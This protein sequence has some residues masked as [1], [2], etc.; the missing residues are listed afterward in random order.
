MTGKMYCLMVPPVES[1][2]VDG[3]P[4]PTGEERTQHLQDDWERDA[5]REGST[6]D[7]AEEELS[8]QEFLQGWF[9]LADNWVEVLDLRRYVDFVTMCYEGI[10]TW[11]L[12]EEGVRIWKD[13]K[14]IFY[15]AAFFGDEEVDRDFFHG[16]EEGEGSL[17]DIPDL[18]AGNFN[19]RAVTPFSSQRCRDVILDIYESRISQMM[20]HRNRILGMSLSM[21]KSKVHHELGTFQQHIVNVFRETYSNAGLRLLAELKSFI[22]GCY[23]HG[24]SRI[25]LLKYFF[26]K[27]ENAMSASIDRTSA[28]NHAMELMMRTFPDCNLRRKFTTSINTFSAVYVDKNLFMDAFHHSVP[29]VPKIAASYQQFLLQVGT[30]LHYKG[31]NAYVGTETKEGRALYIEAKKNEEATRRHFE[32]DAKK[33]RMEGKRGRFIAIN[34]VRRE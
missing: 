27:P 2:M 24:D 3:R 10:S 34:E 17:D 15:N 22:V 19:F 23:Q 25:E 33:R 4:S 12:G 1:R 5:K 14:D 9:E 28:A 26:T 31:T 16:H 13:D 29:H 6:E 21:R 20:N 30:M 11:K 18:F 32:N 7:G 8:F